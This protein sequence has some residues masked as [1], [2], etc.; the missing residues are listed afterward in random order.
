MDL[1]N[2]GTLPKL[3]DTFVTLLRCHKTFTVKS[4][5][6]VSKSDL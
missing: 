1:E 2:A 5:L 3:N 4:E 6:L